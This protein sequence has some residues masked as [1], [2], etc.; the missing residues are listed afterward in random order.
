MI[1]ARIET[2]LT[3]IR[4]AKKPFLKSYL[5]ST[6][7]SRSFELVREQGKRNGISPVIP[8]DSIF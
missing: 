3:M 2:A 8:Y 4:R 1:N 7:H 5:S 6:P